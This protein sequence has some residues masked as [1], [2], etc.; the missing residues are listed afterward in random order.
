MILS[1]KFQR[2]GQAINDLALVPLFFLNQL[3]NLTME[4]LAFLGMIWLIYASRNLFSSSGETDSYSN[5]NEDIYDQE[6]PITPMEVT[7]RIKKIKG[8]LDKAER[9]GRMVDADQVASQK[10]LNSL[11]EHGITKDYVKSR[12]SSMYNDD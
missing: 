12:I 4:A 2:R 6:L 11:K 7:K 1:V 10:I 3:I 5:S 8:I 9:K